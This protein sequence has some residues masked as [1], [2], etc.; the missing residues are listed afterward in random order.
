MLRNSLLPAL[1]LITSFHCSAQAEPLPHGTLVPAAPATVLAC[2]PPAPANWKLTLSHGYNLYSHWQFTVA[3]R[4]YLEVPPPPLPGQPPKTPGTTEIVITDTA[5]YPPRDN[6]FT[7][8]KWGT[9]P[10]QERSTLGDCPAIKT[11]PDPSVTD[12]PEQLMVWVK[13]RFTVYVVTS[14][15]E[16]PANEKWAQLVNYDALNR[17]TDDGPRILVVPLK[18]SGIDELNPANSHTYS[19]FCNPGH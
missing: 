12:G 15:Q 2:L 3:V 14:H 10:N 13:K 4:H 1:L 18:M 17:I 7:N 5:Y 8:P 16:T 11:H 19:L 9:R 6:I